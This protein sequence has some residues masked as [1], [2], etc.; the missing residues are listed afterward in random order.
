[1]KLE[2]LVEN[3]NIEDVAALLYWMLWEDATEDAPYSVEELVE[4]TKKVIHDMR[5]DCDLPTFDLCVSMGQDLFGALYTNIT[6]LNPD[7]ECDPPDN[8]KVYGGDVN[9]KNDCPKGHYNV[10]YRGY[11]QYFGISREKRCQFYGGEIHFLNCSIDNF[12]G[13]EGLLACIVYEL[14]FYGW[15]ESNADD[16]FDKIDKQVD[17]YKGLFGE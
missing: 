8:L 1:M 14:T 6:Y 16:F 11:N 4:L 7:F 2:E 13:N 3:S 5:R 17:E 12:Y 9:F 15:D 10:N